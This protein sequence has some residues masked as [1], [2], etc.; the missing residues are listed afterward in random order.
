MNMTQTTT[1]LRPCP[2]YCE[3]RD[4]GVFHTFECFLRRFGTEWNR[5]AN[6]QGKA[7]NAR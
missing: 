1:E 4:T 7:L 6:N 2:V 3:H 5:S